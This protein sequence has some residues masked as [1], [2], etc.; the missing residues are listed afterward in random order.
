MQFLSDYHCENFAPEH[1]NGQ[2]T[3]FT[4][5]DGSR[6][7]IS[8]SSLATKDAVRIYVGMFKQQA[9]ML[10]A[11]GLDPELFDG[12]AHLCRD[13]AREVRDAMIEFLAATEEEALDQ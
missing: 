11:A 6:V 8:H 4:D 10:R 7:S 5:L 1:G 3:G 2:Y 12:C 13:M 9:D